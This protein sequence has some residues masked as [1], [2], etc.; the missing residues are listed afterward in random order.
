M[1][2]VAF[3]VR[4]ALG[5]PVV[6]IRLGYH[7]TVTTIVQMPKAPMHKNR[8]PMSRKNKIGLTG[9]IGPMKPVAKSHAM[10]Q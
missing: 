6:H 3:H 10:D 5:L 2:G 4:Q 8:L 7:L 1:S 9:K